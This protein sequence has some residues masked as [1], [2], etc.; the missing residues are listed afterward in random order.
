VA[1]AAFQSYRGAALRRW[2]WVCRVYVVVLGAAMVAKKVQV[3]EV[4]WS[5]WSA[6]PGELRLHQHVCM[7][8]L[9]WVVEG[10]DWYSA[11]FGT[12][13]VSSGRALQHMLESAHTTA[14]L[15]HLFG[16]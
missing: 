6:A 14:F 11:F 3:L 12:C 8:M 13:P 1:E 10:C 4:P 5:S 9:V 15:T 2:D 7:T 16:G